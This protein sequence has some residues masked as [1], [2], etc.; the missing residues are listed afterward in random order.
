M[1]A[2][3]KNRL[4]GILIMVILL[5]AD[6]LFMAQLISTKLV[7]AKF[8][9]LGG[10]FLLLILVCVFFMVRNSRNL[11]SLIVGAV[12]TAFFVVIFAV[13]GSYVSEGVNALNA[14]TTVTVE[15]AEVGVYVRADDP[16][17]DIQDA[18][19][20]TFGIMTEQD[21]ENTDKTIEELEVEL[22]SSLNIV[23]YAGFGEVIEALLSTKEIDGMILNSGFIFLLEDVEGYEEAEDQVRE[24]HMAQI[25]TVIEHVVEQS[26]TSILDLF[27]KD[28]G[29]D[30]IASA[31]NSLNINEQTT[32]QAPSADEVGDVFSV[33][34]SGIDSRSSQMIAKSRSDV[35][36]I[37]T[38]NTKTKQV[39]LVSTPRDYY[40][41]LPISNGVPDKLTHA[42]IYG[43]DCSIGT[44]EMLYDIDIDY[45]F[46]VNFTGFEDII[47][48][49]GGINVYSDYTFTSGGYQYYA[50]ENYL[51]GDEALVFARTRKAFAAGDR[52]RGKHQM[53]VIEA[54]IDKAM[55]PS[56]LTNFT[57][58]MESVSGSF[59]TTIPYDLIAK[60]VHDQLDNGGEWNVV[61]MSADG[62]GDSR[63]PY[64]MSLNAYVM[65]PD[66]STVDAAIAKMQ[67][68]IN[69]EIISE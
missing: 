61:S 21:R 36:I 10:V 23:E 64:S 1:S 47:D 38:V 69:G 48:A 12:L 42:G 43:V 8:L 49:L 17:E 29:A 63:K 28:H 60:V 32:Q 59:E 3:M 5:L 15:T 27:K 13:V 41:P 7:P 16:A 50:G 44:L 24:L 19:D 18:A 55:S 31:D 65:V 2:A 20:Y 46:R 37:A 58:I 54:V 33:Y 62:Y 52:Q 34:I 26:P 40:V 25:E 6:V 4:P 57:S 51:Y 39:L 30:E 14:I 22:N 9:I 53:A 35:N 66:Y 45:Y 11:G 56:L 68:V 67:Q